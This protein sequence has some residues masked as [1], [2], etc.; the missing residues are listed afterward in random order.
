MCDNDFVGIMSDRTAPVQQIHF[1]SNG[2]ETHTTTH[3][4][5]HTAQTTT[6]TAAH[7]PPIPTPRQSREDTPPQLPNSPPPPQPTSH[8]YMDEVTVS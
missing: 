8:Q 5:A 2:A 1:D 3:T 6:H 4:S 7:Q